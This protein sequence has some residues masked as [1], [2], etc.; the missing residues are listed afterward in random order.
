MLSCHSAPTKFV[1]WHAILNKPIRAEA[2]HEYRC[3]YQSTTVLGTRLQERVKCT[4]ICGCRLTAHP[5]IRHEKHACA[6]AHSV[7]KFRVCSRAVCSP[8]ARVGMRSAT[9]SFAHA[10]PMTKIMSLLMPRRYD[11]APQPSDKLKHARCGVSL[12]FCWELEN[13]N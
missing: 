2:Q 11:K 9:W 4:L 5:P 12:T 1:F 3:S 10:T 7:S 13:S 6:Q 8:R